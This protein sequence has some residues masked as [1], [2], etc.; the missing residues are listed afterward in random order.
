MVKVFKPG[1]SA[2]K[3]P[4][5]QVTELQI[6]ALDHQGRGVAKTSP[7]TFVEG[8]LPGEIC[9]ARITTTRKNV[10]F[11]QAETIKTTADARQI[12]P[13][14]YF[15]SCGGCQTQY[16][17]PK[18]MISYKQQALSSLIEKFTGI[19]ADALPWQPVVSGGG[20]GY[21]RKARLAVDC[22]DRQHIKTGFRGKDG[23]TVVNIS[24]CQVLHPALS[25]LLDPL[26]SLVKKLSGK[27]HIGHIS[28]F[29]GTDGVQVTLRSTKP[30]S[31]DDMDKLRRFQTSQ[32]CHVQLEDNGH[33]LVSLYPKSAEARYALTLEHTTLSLTLMPGDFVQVNDA[34]NQQMVQQALN[35]LELSD[36]DNCLDLFC[37]I[38]N[39]TL[40]IA[41]TGARVTGFEVSA[42]MVQRAKH[43]AQQNG[44]QDVEFICGDLAQ[45]DVLAKLDAMEF[46]KVL[47]DPAR[48]GAYEAVQRL[49]ALQP[50][51]ILYVSCNPATFGRDIALLTSQGYH[52]AKIS[53]LDMFPYTSHTEV[54]ALFERKAP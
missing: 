52:M 27:R 44:I 33:Q 19:A 43:N 9:R 25:Q 18:A 13:C 6:T 39:F 49:V 26:N 31:V 32:Q 42:E 3:K 7:V 30:L 51:R 38:G 12:P 24:R 5:S 37:G 45:D 29:Y 53:L 34:V 48:A 54:M 2:K 21:R 50:E 47:L 46:N 22:R 8:A 40:P 36:V 23:N 4:A 17:Q 41:T 15:A 11:A 1:K 20:Q 28:L 35:W 14:E 10:R 16:C